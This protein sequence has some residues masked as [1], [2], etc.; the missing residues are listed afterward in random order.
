MVA[1]RASMAISSDSTTAST[2]SEEEEKGKEET[3]EKALM[4]VGS[5]TNGTWNTLL[6]K[7]THA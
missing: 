3:S 7:V 5:K 1:S 6:A 4:E 2:G